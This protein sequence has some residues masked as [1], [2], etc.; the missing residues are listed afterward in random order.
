MF[1]SKGQSGKPLATNV[2]YG[3][4]KDPEDK[5]HWLVDEAAAV[6]VRE[7]F[8]LCISGYGPSHIARMLTERRVMNPT[9]YARSRG[10]NIPD[11]REYTDD[12]TWGTS[13]ITHMLARQEYLGRTVNFK[14]H[15]KSYKQKKLLRMIL[16]SGL[17][18]R[19]RTRQSSTRKL[20]ILCNEFV[21]EDA[22]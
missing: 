11:N 6:I 17:F 5:T 10:V 16:R 14:T 18:S 3:Y 12:Y 15:R 21:T 13:T 19:T 1:K 20:S 4:R 8:H 7:V 22:A 9:A 2:P